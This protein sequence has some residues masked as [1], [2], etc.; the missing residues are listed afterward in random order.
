M[1]LV[2]RIERKNLKYYLGD[3]NHN[4]MALFEAAG[5]DSGVVAEDSTIVNQ[6]LG[7][8]WVSLLQ[9]YTFLEFLDLCA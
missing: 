3:H 6:L 8:Y 7:S 4:E 1:Q 9:L 5:L 2:W